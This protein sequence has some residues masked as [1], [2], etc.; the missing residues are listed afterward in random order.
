MQFY[1][2]LTR[3]TITITPDKAKDWLPIPADMTVYPFSDPY[4]LVM[5]NGSLVQSRLEGELYLKLKASRMAGKK[6]GSPIKELLKQSRTEEVYPEFG[7]C[8]VTGRYYPVKKLKWRRIYNK[9]L[10]CVEPRISG[11]I[12]LQDKSQW[13]KKDDARLTDLVTYAG[14]NIKYASSSLA[15]AGMRGLIL[16]EIE[17]R[18]IV[19]DESV[20]LRIDGS[21]TTR[22]SRL[23][24][25]AEE[26]GQYFHCN[27]CDHECAVS[28]R[29]S[30]VLCTACAANIASENSHGRVLNYSHKVERD[31][32]FDDRECIRLGEIKGSDK[33]TG[34][35]VYLGAEL[36]FSIPGSKQQEVLD[37]IHKQRY[38]QCKSDASISNGFEIVTKPCSIFTHRKN[39]TE[40]FT[41]YSNVLDPHRT[42]GLH[43]HVSRV[44]NNGEIGKVT[45]FLNR[46]A[47][48]DFV[49]GIARRDNN[50][51]AKYSDKAVSNAIVREGRFG[52]KGVATKMMS[53]D[54]RTALNIK[55]HTLEFRIF[56]ASNDLNTVM[57][58]IQFCEALFMYAHE[59]K[60]LSLAEWSNVKNFVDYLK[61][62]VYKTN[63]VPGK[64]TEK[65]LRYAELLNYIESNKL[66]TVSKDMHEIKVAK[67]TKS[68][69]N[70]VNPQPR[71]MELPNR[72]RT[73]LANQLAKSGL[74]MSQ[75]L[76][77]NSNT[78]MWYK[79]AW[80][81]MDYKGNVMLRHTT[82]QKAA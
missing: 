37:F 45:H 66:S 42:C 44:F 25:G 58:S 23:E 70:R 6:K 73:D 79:D 72:V 2:N 49:V 78:V 18:Y 3:E 16:S 7:L 64:P 65:V 62:V 80:C 39:L 59:V 76:E 4:E 11:F 60:S 19:A 5:L 14:E 38:A 29:V 9:K 43:V 13:V 31:L 71:H 52:S 46:E 41:K 32:G 24:R 74:L 53:G 68:L 1:T 51:Y 56:A 12:W 61:R 30:D 17:N 8:Q 28:M 40:L 22:I 36:E 82:E 26:F 67:I 34:E 48:R 63:V 81:L 54:R 57:A 35:P 50:Q 69:V 20:R 15:L 27:H 10:Y 75:W 21:N 77:N 47:N 33:P 55:E